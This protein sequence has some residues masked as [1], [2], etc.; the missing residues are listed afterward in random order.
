MAKIVGFGDVRRVLASKFLEL[1]VG[2]L[3]AGLRGAD[4]LVETSFGE[5]LRVIESDLE[6]PH[7]IP[8]N[9]RRKVIEH[10][11]LYLHRQDILTLNHGMTVMRWAMTIEVKKE[12]KRKTFLKE[13]YLRLD[14]H[15]REKLI[16]VH[17]MREYAE[18]ALKEMAEALRLVLN[19]FTDSKQ[20]FIKRHFNGREDVLKLATSEESWKSI[21]ESL[22][23]TQNV[24]YDASRTDPD[25]VRVR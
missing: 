11:L 21:I 6:L 17:V 9:R 15:Y 16:Q 22:S 1:L 4:L 23:T 7:L 18:V 5:L 13:D 19:Y 2:K 3:P 10:V 20:A 25:V 14:E 24:G 8:P 12:D